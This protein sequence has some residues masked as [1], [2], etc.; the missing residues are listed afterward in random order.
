MLSSRGVLLGGVTPLYEGTGMCRNLGYTF[1]TIRSGFLGT[2]LDIHRIFDIVSPELWVQIQAGCHFNLL[3]GDPIL[4]YCEQ[5]KFSANNTLSFILIH[6]YAH[7]I[8]HRRHL[9]ALVLYSLIT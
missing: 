7:Q 9:H 2:I 4:V 8:T 1:E 3:V 6:V 5:N